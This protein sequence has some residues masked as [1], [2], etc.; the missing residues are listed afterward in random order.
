M[1]P[2]DEFLEHQLLDRFQYDDR[3]DEGWYGPDSPRVG[4]KG[5]ITWE[6][7]TG[8]EGASRPF[9]IVRDDTEHVRPEG[10]GLPVLMVGMMDD[11]RRECVI[12]D[13]EDV[14]YMSLLEADLDGGASLTLMERAYGH[15]RWR[16][17]IH[18]E[19]CPIDLYAPDGKPVG[20]V[21]ARQTEPGEWR[22]CDMYDGRPLD[23]A[24]GETITDALRRFG[25][26]LE[27][28]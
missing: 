3:H 6:H 27:E 7:P 19:G 26:E 24:L 15:A 17:N 16:G 2:L 21:G 23:G 11:G 1:K 12:R 28:S 25:Y 13:G 18:G 8:E 5:W 22:I 4:D 14:S 9:E 20:A 10:T